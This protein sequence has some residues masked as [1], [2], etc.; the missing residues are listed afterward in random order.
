MFPT[1]YEVSQGCILG[2]LLFLLYIIDLPVCSSLLKFI[3]FVDD[4]NV[5]WCAWKCLQLNPSKTEVIWFDTSNSLKKLS[6]TDVSLRIETDTISP[7]KLVHDL[8]VIFDNELSMT[9]HVNK[10]SGV[11]F[12]QLRRLKKIRRILNPD[13]TARLV[14]AYIISRLDYYNSVLAGLPKS[15][16]APLQWVQNS[17]ARLV[18]RF[19]PRVHISSTLLDLHWLPLNFRTMY[20]LCLKI[21]GEHNHCCQEYI[22]RLVTST[23]SIP[24]R[25]KLRSATSN[26]YK[27]AK[28]AS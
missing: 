2:L 26:R 16:T 7:T 1:V 23:A 4:T 17:A 25:S 28:N 10:I 22:S 19:G 27:V 5:F 8:G 15:T 24:L 18:K 11:L 20:K 21:H 13:I 6:G 9:I 14:S 12:Y 3:L